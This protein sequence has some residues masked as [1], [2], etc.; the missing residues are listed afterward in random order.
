MKVRALYYA[1]GS[2]SDAPV[3]ISVRVSYQ[4]KPNGNDPGGTDYR[5]AQRLERIPSLIFWADEQVPA[6]KAVVAISPTE[7]YAVSAVQ[8][9]DLV[10]VSAF[11]T[12][13]GAAKAAQYDYP[14]S[15]SWPESLWS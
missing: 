2:S 14:G 12:S 4:V 10:T 8:P 3:P 13:L 1:S 7:V 5:F 15:M 9:P 11:V 6:N